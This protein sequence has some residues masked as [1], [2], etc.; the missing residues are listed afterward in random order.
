MYNPFQGD[1]MEKFIANIVQ[2]IKIKDR[3]VYINDVC[4]EIF[5]KYEDTIPMIKFYEDKNWKNSRLYHHKQ[6]V[7]HEKNF[8]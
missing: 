5:T 7:V 6:G 4:Q 3:D 2:S 8:N 1:I